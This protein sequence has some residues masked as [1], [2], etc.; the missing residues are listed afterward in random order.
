[1]RTP[2][3]VRQPRRMEHA[4]EPETP[5]ASAPFGEDAIAAVDSLGRAYQMVTRASG[6]SHSASPS[7][8]ANAS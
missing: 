3:R 5:T 6:E 8:T 4:R 2:R 1:M 7:R